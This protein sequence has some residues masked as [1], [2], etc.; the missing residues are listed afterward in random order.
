MQRRII[1]DDVVHLVFDAFDVVCKRT[2]GRFA[3]GFHIPR[4]VAMSCVL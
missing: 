4:G 3:T 1:A 2:D